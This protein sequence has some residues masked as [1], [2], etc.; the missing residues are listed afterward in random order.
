MIVAN[1]V[2][3]GVGKFDETAGGA[4]VVMVLVENRHERR[5]AEW[6]RM[7]GAVAEEI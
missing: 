6:G 4:V 3:I 7:A 5:E 2:K 1:G